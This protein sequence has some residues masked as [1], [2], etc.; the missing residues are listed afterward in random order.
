MGSVRSDIWIA[1]AFLRC[2]ISSVLVSSINDRRLCHHQRDV[3]CPFLFV[4]MAP[5]NTQGAW[6]CSRRNGGFSVIVDAVFR[7]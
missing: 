5:R 2:A 4:W 7:V 3:D 1:V 6:H